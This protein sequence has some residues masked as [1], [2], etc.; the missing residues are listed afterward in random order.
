MCI[1]QEEAQRECWFPPGC[2][3]SW[4]EASCRSVRS[5]GVKG[6]A[7]F[8]AR[9]QP[10][11][12]SAPVRALYTV[13]GGAVLTIWN[14]PGETKKYL[15]SLPSSE[16]S[17][18]TPSWGIL[19]KACARLVKVSQRLPG[20]ASRPDCLRVEMAT[21]PWTTLPGILTCW[22]SMFPQVEQEF[23]SVQLLIHVRLFVTP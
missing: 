14:S 20:Q 16:F 22:A 12:S 6:A 4:A 21:A 3:G 9:R 7:A 17:E 13:R 11:L 8:E 1:T 23:S 10:V 2:W 5:A 18:E 19:R 15:N